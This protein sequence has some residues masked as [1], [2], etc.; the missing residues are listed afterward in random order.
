MTVIVALLGSD[1]GKLAGVAARLKAQG[2]DVCAAPQGEAEGLREAVLRCLMPRADVVLAAW[3]KAD[4]ALPWYIETLQSAARSGKLIGLSVDGTELPVIPDFS[5]FSS[6]LSL[7]ALVAE[8]KARAV[9]SER[10]TPKIDAEYATFRS[11]A[12]AGEAQS[13]RAFLKR[14]PAG[15]FAD[16]AH[17]ELGLSAAPAYRS[18]RAAALVQDGRES[19]RLQRSSSAWGLSLALAVVA[20]G[21]ALTVGLLRSPAPRPSL[22]AGVAAPPPPPTQTM[23]GPIDAAAEA[24]VADYSLPL[25]ATDRPVRLADVARTRD[26]ADLA[27]RPRFD[28]PPMASAPQQ[29]PSPLPEL[30]TAAAFSPP[31]DA[32][33]LTPS[34]QALVDQAR[35]RQGYGE[36]RA[37]QV[38][39]ARALSRGGL[40]AS[41]WGD[42]DGGAANGMGVATFSNGDRYAGSWRRSAPD[43]M[44]VLQLASGVR[45]EGEFEDGAPTGRG[46]FWSADGRRL[47]DDEAFRVL[48]MARA[49]QS[50]R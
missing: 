18:P 31:F 4:L 23:I 21:G 45:Y 30:R 29:A 32:T 46:V 28:L 9:R 3:T 26:V 1:R 49:A 16:L 10:R 25:S 35:R 40:E 37:A 17:A 44:G 47:A 14:Y 11:A 19:W 39:R 15:V 8:A 6:S 41:Y 2:Y 33:P 12:S 24:A 50:N 22:V 27:P 7:D 36:A 34:A 43:G 5:G 42:W 20:A 38:E 48:M 13:W